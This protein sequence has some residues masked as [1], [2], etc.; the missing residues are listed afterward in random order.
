MI[1]LTGG[2]QPLTVPNPVLLAA[3][4]AGFGDEYA[5]LIDLS[6]MGGL[7]TSPL[8]WRP[9]R[10][11]SGVRVVPLDGG[12]LVHTGLPNPGVKAAIQTHG[13]AWG[14][15]PCPVIVHI[16]AESADDMRQCVEALHGLAG[17]AAIEIGVLD[18]SGPREVQTVVD[19]AVSHIELPVIARLPL[20]TAPLLASAAVN[21]GA[22]AL[23]VSAPPRGTARDPLS[24][25][26][27]GGRT[28]G[29][30]L[31]PL[32][33]RTVGQ[34]AREVSIPVIACGGI[35]TPDDARDFLAAGAK[36]IQLDSVV[37]IRPDLAEI[38]A[39]NLSGLE[40]TRAVGALADEW[41]P[42]LGATAALRIPPIASPPPRPAK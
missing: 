9:R 6:L 3:G 27:V 28:Y 8:T 31:K 19:A 38:I 30:W 17:V 15:S 34:V 37:W 35:H 18:S 21:A 40:L 4:I 1:E 2:K 33:L 23:T 12:V 13:P 20:Y 41:Q 26:L 16:A 42:G 14:R 32:A 10:A 36:A 5:R 24:G 22:G 11:A 25:Q 7:V 39:R 29:P